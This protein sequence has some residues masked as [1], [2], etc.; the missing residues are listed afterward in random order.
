GKRPYELGWA[1][2]T[3]PN[4]PQ[5]VD[6]EDLTGWQVRC[7]DGAEARFIRSRRELL[8]GEY[9]GRVVYA[10]R[11][12]RSRFVLEPVE[13]IV[14]PGPFTG[15]NLWVRGNNWGWI[16][17][18]KTARVG[19]R[20]LVRDAK[21]EDY[22]IPLGG[23]DF[24]YWSLMHATCVSPD[25][26]HR[27]YEA[28]GAGNDGV[29]DFP[30]RFVGIEVS[31]CAS[32]E[33]AQLYLDA[34]SFY[35]IE[36]PP[37]AF[38]P[39][40]D[41]LPWPT[42]PNTLLPTVA[43]KLKTTIGTRQ[44]TAIGPDGDTAKLVWT[45]TVTDAADEPLT[46]IFDPSEGT[47]SG[48]TVGFRGQRFHPCWKGS[49]VFEVDGKPIRPGDEGTE[50]ACLDIEQA[51]GLVLGLGGEESMTYEF[52]LKVGDKAFRYSYKFQVK[53]KS[54]VIDVD[55]E[56][57]D[58]GN[59]HAAYLDLGLAKGLKDAKAVFFPYLTYGD[60]WPRVVCSGDVEKPVFLLSLLDYFNSD[61]SELFGAPRLQEEGCVAYAGGAAYKATTT[62]K[63]IPLRER[64]FVNVSGDV[65]EV[66]PNIP[67]PR[68]DTGAV[69]REYV[70]RN[71]GHVFQ[72]ELLS[73]YQV[74][75]IDKFIACHHEVGWREG[76]ESFTLRDRPATSIGQEALAEYGAFVKGLGYRFGTYTNYVDF[77]PVNADWNENDVC[78]DSE[79]RWQRAWPRCYALKPLRAVEKEAEYAPRINERYG[80][81]AQYCD[82]HTAYKPWGRT[83]YDARTPGAG[84]FRTQYDAFAR[85]LQ[86]E[87]KAHKG[88][89]FSE[90]NYHWFY[91]GIADGNYA[92][93]VPYGQGW[94]LPQLVDFDLLKMHPK[95]TDFG[96]GMPQMY[97]GQQGAWREDGSR[98]SPWFDRFHTATIAFG[99][100]GFLAND[101]G[102]DGTLKSYYLLQALQQRYAM[103]PVESIGY[104][105]GEEVVDTSAALVSDAYKRGQVFV[106][107]ENGLE[108]WCNLSFNHDWFV[109]PEGWRPYVLPPG[110]FLAYREGDILAYSAVVD[111]RRHEYV[112]CADYVYVD[113][114]GQVVLTPVLA[115]RGAVAVKPDGEGGWWVIPATESEEVTIAL[116]WLLGT[117]Q[118]PAAAR[119]SEGEAR[120][121]LAERVSDLAG[122]V[123]EIPGR[124]PGIE[125]LFPARSVRFV[126]AA[127]D[128]AGKEIGPAVVRMG[129]ECVTVVPSAPESD[130]GTAAERTPIRYRLRTESYDAAKAGAWRFEVPSWRVLQGTSVPVT[131]SVEV[132]RGMDVSDATLAYGREI[133]ESAEPVMDHARLMRPE[134]ETVAVATVNLEVPKT[135]PHTRCWYRFWLTRTDAQPGEPRWLDLIA[136]P[137]FDIAF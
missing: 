100:I 24:D 7:F 110:G 30:A 64:L 120:E 26:K 40:P 14:I 117:E 95:M 75:G 27:H 50:V 85:L 111:G 46:Y 130:V 102:F 38:E 61:A 112:Q 16:N 80:T 83:D 89:V 114:R 35:E 56:G 47:L 33:P 93:M 57:D 37:L 92:T 97:F 105:G 17:P 8:F 90:G 118:G 32:S 122:R 71:M 53:G 132:P 124:L 109:F 70:W 123:A 88:P 10:G 1:G 28:L 128:L 103:I 22:S 79:G 91:A 65:H 21:D 106:E 3:E 19:I 115:T 48:L 96:M 121:S 135:E 68:C 44:Q 12:A 107:Y 34:L 78:L 82:V 74:H 39:L 76:G 86:N 125:G 43:G 62:G 66:L 23:V 73:K 51:R 5:L 136:A 54:L 98:L 9:T 127:Y 72:D 25:G 20:V 42:T 15:V 137:P 11:T 104:F 29:I 60:D 36:Y 69:A 45:A 55:C 116:S 49:V 52:E 113:T 31:G 41:N 99:H 18:P 59:G 58:A 126:A 101:W 134:G 13:P 119:P 108:V 133:P 63:R 81:T 67:T 2:R 131:V 6:F 94:E 84:M 129:D 77:A 4:H 87:S